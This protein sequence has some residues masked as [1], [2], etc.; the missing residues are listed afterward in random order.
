MYDSKTATCTYVLV[1]HNVYLRFTLWKNVSQPLQQFSSVWIRSISPH[2]CFYNRTGWIQPIKQWLLHFACSLRKVTGPKAYSSQRAIDG[3]VGVILI[4]G[5]L[6]TLSAW[7]KK[8]GNLPYT[9]KLFCVSTIKSSR[10]TKPLSN[11]NDF[12]ILWQW[13]SLKML[14]IIQLIYLLFKTGEVKFPHDLTAG[15]FN[16]CGFYAT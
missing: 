13:S 11:L 4:T 5:S 16:I 3:P 8:I 6:P 10:Y 1:S 15:K 2:N 12:H 7:R 9:S 14:S